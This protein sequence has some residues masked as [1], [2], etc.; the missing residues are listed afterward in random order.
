[1]WLKLIKNE[2]V[3]EVRKC[4]VKILSCLMAVAMLVGSFGTMA[5]A[6]NTATDPTYNHGQIQVSASDTD[7]V[8][9]MAPGDTSEIVVSPYIHV[10]YAGCGM[11]ACPASCEEK[12]GGKFTCWEVGKGCICDQTLNTC[13]GTVNVTSNNESVVKSGSISAGTVGSTVGSTADGKVTLTAVGAGET[14]VEVTAELRDWISVSK[15]YT[16]KVVDES[17]NQTVKEG[18][19]ITKGGTYTIASDA[20]N[21]TITVNTTEPVTLVGNGSNSYLEIACVKAYTDLTIENLHFKGYTDDNQ[22]YISFTGKGNTLTVK[23]TNILEKC[24]KQD[25]SSALIY[26]PSGAELTID[27]D[28]VLNLYH[29]TQTG[30]GAAIGGNS[31]GTAGDIEFA[32]AKTLIYGYMGGTLIG[33]PNGS[34]KIVFSGGE[35]ALRLNMVDSIFGKVGSEKIYLT[36]GTLSVFNPMTSAGPVADEVVVTGGSLKLSNL[37]D[38]KMVDDQGNEVALCEISMGVS[39]SPYTVTVDNETFYNG[40]G[41]IYTDSGSTQVNG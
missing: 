23:G 2:E 20:G 40:N 22:N 10:Q 37:S 41:H 36:G 9:T 19:A 25:G 33:G 13:T 27:G 29:N 14:T 5:F 39:A 24:Y 21:G 17:A 30:A 11:T 38:G 8:I 28:G 32:G 16:V 3:R 12:A 4:K 6:A 34:G 15:T 31:R 18:D 7:G 1:M 35:V 26:V